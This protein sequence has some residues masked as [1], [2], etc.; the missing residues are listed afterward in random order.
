MNQNRAQRYPAALLAW[1]GLILGFSVGLFLDQAANLP[2]DGNLLPALR[3]C[4]YCLP[5]ALPVAAEVVNV[6][7]WTLLGALLGLVLG[8]LVAAWRRVRPQ[9]PASPSKRLSSF[10]QAAELARFSRA[11]SDSLELPEILNQLHEEVVRVTGA[12][13]G[14]SFLLDPESPEH[15]VAV[16][17]GEGAELQR[18]SAMETAAVSAGRGRLVQD[19]EMEGEAPP[20]VGV[21]AALLAP[22]TYDEQAIGLIHLHS[23]QPNAFDLEFYDFVLV[24]AAQAAVALQNSRR[25]AEQ[26]RRSE[27]LRQ[28]I[29][30]LQQLSQIPNAVRIDRSL[31]TNLQ[32]IAQTM[33]ETAD[34]SLVLASAFA[35][36]GNQLVHTASA[37]LSP[38]AFESLQQVP[39]PWERLQPFLREENRSERVYRVPHTQTADLFQALDLGRPPQPAAP[40]APGQ[41]H[42]DDLLLVPLYGSRGQIEG[43]L[44]VGLPREPRTPPSLLL[45]MLEVFASQ[46]ALAIENARLITQSEERVSES[47]ARAVQLGVLTEAAGVMAAALHVDEVVAV[48]LDQLRRVIPYDTAALWQRALGDGRWRVLGAR[49]FEDSLERVLDRSAGAQATLFSEIVASRSVVFVPDVSRDERFSAKEIST[50]RSW[51]GVP[52]LSSGEVIG[53]LALEKGADN[54]YGPAHVPLALSFAN[55][56]AAALQH[57]RLYE[58]SVQRAQELEQENARRAQDVALRAQRLALLNHIATHLAEA[59]D[60]GSLLRLTLDTLTQALGV[61][62]ASGMILSGE[63]D[64]EAADV[65]A[66]ARLPAGPSLAPAV[67]ALA[68]NPLLDRL[69]ET[70]APLAAEAGSRL[71]H[72]LVR[73]E[74]FAWVGAD[75][76]AALFLPLLA[77]GRLL[78]VIGLGGRPFSAAEAELGR[79]IVQQTLTAL[80]YLQ[81]RDRTQEQA[82]VQQLT[83]AIGRAQDFHQL[84]QVI[85]LQLAE[86]AGVD[87]F[88]LALYDAARDRVS[89]PLLVEKSQVIDLA[90]ARDGRTPGGL[91]GHLLHTQQSVRLSGDV[92]AQ[93]QALGLAWGL[94]DQHP[95]RGGPEAGPAPLARSYLGV[96]LSLGDRLVGALVAHDPD[97][98]DAFDERTER[99]L[100][101][102]SSQLAL[103]ITN[104]N[105]F[106][107][108]RQTA[109]SSQARAAQFEALADASLAL[110]AAGHSADVLA[111]A[112]DQ[113]RGLVPYTTATFWQ[114]DA[115]SAEGHAAPVGW[116]AAAVRGFSDAADRLGQ[117]RALAPHT[118]LGEVLAARQVLLVPDVRQD[119]RFESGAPAA[120]WMAV[121]VIRQGE[122]V[123]LIEMETI[124]PASLYRRSGAAGAVAGRAGGPG[125]AAGR[126]AGRQPAAA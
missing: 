124:G 38:D 62:Q 104:L 77:E 17:V 51:L 98:P 114:R 83:R 26:A 35:P 28:R 29:N 37:G 97:R 72:G 112:L 43:L 41:W 105:L 16:R 116:R 53:V 4:H 82:G 25:Y 32:A 8:V 92:A 9:P 85:R 12:D 66:A 23:Q 31:T 108:A 74:H 46:A 93:A 59:R 2:F 57:A 71:T 103:A 100:A 80:Q 119:D 90:G 24:L 45:E 19:F 56:L 99:L 1:L 75:V 101:G 102:A 70:G 39:L 48:S 44:S 3:A 126:A 18:L 95:V 49:S 107:Q 22:I 64:R 6:N 110:A 81:L 36:A 65:L 109:A 86:V 27:A 88:S 106:E 122:V 42:P 30:Q 115:A 54:F 67:L 120:S 58:E 76:S 91:V 123:G 89:F 96:P 20:H 68:G 52:L 79:A 7:R 5:A 69:Q 50:L 60:L 33:Q 21:R 13:C 121:P 34:F 10:R 73:A 14:S 47:Q 113:F 84:Y 63:A 55:R 40:A 125:P 118:P 15:R 117:T 11:L 61:T 78:G 94:P 111:A 87:S